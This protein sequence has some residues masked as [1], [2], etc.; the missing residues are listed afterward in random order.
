MVVELFR[1][2]VITNACIAWS[3][4]DNELKPIILKE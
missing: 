4:I 1:E 2:V 3:Q